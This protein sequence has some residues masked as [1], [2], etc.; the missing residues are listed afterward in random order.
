[1]QASNLQASTSTAPF[2]LK[3]NCILEGA[4]SSFKVKTL[5]SSKTVD[6]LKDAIKERK[7]NDLSQIDADRLILKLIKSDDETKRTTMGATKK[8]LQDE[9]SKISFQLLNELKTLHFYFSNQPAEDLVHILVEL[10]QQAPRDGGSPKRDREEESEEPMKRRRKLE[11]WQPYR[12]TDGNLVL[13]PP[14]MLDILRSDELKPDP[15]T[16]FN[17]LLNVRAG[18]QIT[19]MKLGEN[20]KFFAQ[21][22]Q[23]HEF[24]VTEQMMTL[25]EELE[26]D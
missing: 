7:K 5:S 25:W 22:Y 10:P 8:E 11:K 2:D 1:M 24:I 15:R 26:S 6:D 21:G 14:F 17:S 12:A 19:S 20:P 4:E 16:S 23:G 13:L 9:P 3:L 18:N